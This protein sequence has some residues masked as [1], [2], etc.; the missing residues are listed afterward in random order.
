MRKNTI[1]DVQ[2]AFRH[3]KVNTSNPNQHAN[4]VEFSDNLVIRAVE[5]LDVENYDGNSYWDEL[6]LKRNTFRE[7]GPVVVWDIPKVLCKG[8]D[9]EDMAYVPAQ[10]AFQFRGIGDLRMQGCSVDG[11][12]RGVIVTNCAK[13]ALV[14][15]WLG[16]TV[17]GIPITDGGG[18]GQL[19]LLDNDNGLPPTTLIDG[20]EFEAAT[21]TVIDG[22]D[23]DDATGTFYDGGTF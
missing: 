2:I 15:N 12:A 7:C 21:T 19:I 9:V 17:D 1:Q 3:Y 6:I 11:A 13:A 4:R 14:R 10:H 16:E 5:P 23:F 8:N 18:N 20:G 22:G